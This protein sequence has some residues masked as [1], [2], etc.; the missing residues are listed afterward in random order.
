MN[1]KYNF[2]GSETAVIKDSNGLTPCDYYDILSNI[3]CADTCAPRLRGIWSKENKTLGQCSVTAF[4]MQDIFGGKVYGIP[5]EDGNFHCF[6]AVGD[7]VFD[8]TSE[9][10]GNEKLDYNNC[11]EQLR[12]IHFKKEEKHKRYEYLKTE[13]LKSIPKMVTLLPLTADDREQFILDNQEA[14]NY[15]ALEE[16][17]RR[18]DHF[19]DDGEIISRKTIERCIDGGEAFRIIC[20][21]EKVGGV[22][23]K[24]EGDKG[25]LELLFVKP[26]AHSKG[27]GYAA[28]CEIEK[29]YPQVKVWETVTPY[30]EK[31]NIHFYVNRCKFKIVEFYCSH[32]P[33]PNDPETG[34]ENTFDGEENGGMFRFE[35]R[36]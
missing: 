17:G 14:F 9:Q 26:L 10:F 8:L 30:F 24:V 33:D 3:W 25:D 15:G 20:K 21:N 1:K 31:R 36:M 5:L 4:L 6:N 23:V 18:D 35:K 16:F 11:T 13:L 12:E 28:W 27:I 22:V 34:E 29:L 7:C 32:H 19:E 2:Y